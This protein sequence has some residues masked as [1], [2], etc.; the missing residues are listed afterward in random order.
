MVGPWCLS[1]PSC[2]WGRKSWRKAIT[3]QGHPVLPLC[4]G[5]V[6]IF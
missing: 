5:D 3:C 2:H 1:H 4:T 6:G